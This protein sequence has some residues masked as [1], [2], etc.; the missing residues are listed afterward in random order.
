MSSINPINGKPLK[1]FKRSQ[2]ER[3]TPLRRF[4]LL[5]S[6]PLPLPP[7]P[8]VFDWR[9]GI[10]LP[11]LGNDTVGDCFYAAACHLA[12]IW[13]GQHGP[14]ATFD[15]NAVVARY[16]VISGGDNGLGDDQIFPEFTKCGII[17]PDG[18]YKILDH[19]D[20]DTSDMTLVDKAIYFG[21]GVFFT[22]SLA[23]KW[24]AN[25]QPGDVWDVAPPNDNNG[26]AMILAGKDKD[27]LYPIETWGFAPKDRIRITPKAL[28]NCHPE[29]VVCISRDQFAANGY[30]PH[31]IYYDQAKAYWS[32]YGGIAIPPGNYPPPTPIPQPTPVNPPVPAPAPPAPVMP[33]AP[34]IG[35]LSCHDLNVQIQTA[36][37]AHAKLGLLSADTATAT[38][39]TVVHQNWTNLTAPN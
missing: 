25:P 21:I 5:P 39:A 26:H 30:A 9:N 16:K 10:D 15:R 18:Q 32:S 1:F 4:S 37:R 12:Q 38:A 14:A 19:L 27:G 8:A 24:I 13:T 35:K 31:N 3:T 23:D 36:M 28:E 20:V 11:I 2:F 33:P 6:S 22:A 17:G 34:P 29:I 7:Y